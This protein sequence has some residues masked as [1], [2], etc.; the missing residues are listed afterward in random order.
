MKL[1]VWVCIKLKQND[2]FCFIGFTPFDFSPLLHLRLLFLCLSDASIVRNH[3]GKS[4]KK[5]NT[6]F[7]SRYLARASSNKAAPIKALALVV[8]ILATS[9]SVNAETF[10]N[11]EFLKWNRETQEF[12]I[13]TSIGMAGLIAAQNDKVIQE[14]AD[15]WYLSD[16]PKTISDII[17]AMRKFPKFHP[18][19]V[20]LAVMEKHCGSFTFK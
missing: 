8:C 20:I 13:D 14:C 1:P 7:C 12:Y 15:K 17:S 19:A 10:K 18:R 5:Q 16:K 2:V 4:T 6:S 9:T 3:C 11:S